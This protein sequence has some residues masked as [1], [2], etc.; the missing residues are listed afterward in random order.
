MEW[1]RCSNRTRTYII[2]QIEWDHPW[3]KGQ[4]SYPYDLYFTRTKSVIAFERRRQLFVY[5]DWKTLKSNHWS[6]IYSMI[7]SSCTDWFRKDVWNSKKL[8]GQ[9][10]CFL[11]YL[12]RRIYSHLLKILPFLQK[13]ILQRY[14][15]N[16]LFLCFEQTW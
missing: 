5:S 14:F 12:K 9:L 2:L 13:K 4:V 1:T 7:I 8:Q 16:V 3:G 11:I 10:F 6:K 15:F